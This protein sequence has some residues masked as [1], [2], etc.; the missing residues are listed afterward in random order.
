MPFA[1]C[2][3]KGP[4]LPKYAGE[5]GPPYIDGDG[6][7]DGEGDAMSPPR[8]DRDER[9]LADP[10]RGISESR[11][12]SATFSIEERCKTWVLICRPVPPRSAGVIVGD[13]F[14]DAAVVLICGVDSPC[15]GN[16]LSFALRLRKR[17]N[18]TSQTHTPKKVATSMKD[19]SLSPANLLPCP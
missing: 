2:G 7:A 13:P 17:K 4:A 19:S 8:C 11:G 9:N 15:D 12:S 5:A 10:I 18:G 6:G 3:E 16:T 1:T 14:S